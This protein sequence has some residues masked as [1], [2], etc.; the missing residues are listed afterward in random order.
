MS[1]LSPHRELYEENLVEPIAHRWSRTMSFD[2]PDSDPDA[3]VLPPPAVTTPGHRPK[4]SIRMDAPPSLRIH[5]ARFRRRLGAG[6]SPSTSS[7]VEDS[8][9][10]SNVGP[11]GDSQRESQYEDDRDVDEVVVDRNWSDDIKSTIS[12]SEESISGVHSI[13]GPGP[14]TDR[15]S[16]AVHASGGATTAG[17][18]SLC[19]PLIIL[20]W[21]LFPAILHFF[22][23]KFLNQ[24][25]ELHYARE[26]W[27]IHKVRL[28]LC[29]TM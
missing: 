9:A 29:I 20:R 13:S 27:F 15:D 12:L 5:W 25:S 18:W 28:S 11:R 23:P 10:G 24:K 26:T 7:L 1:P 4:K 2:E 19:T 3:L 8:A 17:F 22:S 14:C 6:P 16:A 21:H